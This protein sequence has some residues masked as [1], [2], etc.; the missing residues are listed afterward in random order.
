MTPAALII[1]A[2]N[3]SKINGSANPPL[4]ASYNGFVNGDNAGVL[5][6]APVLNVNA[7]T[8]SPVAGNP[9]AITVG[10]AAA[11]N[12]SISYVNGTLT[13]L[14]ADL[15]VSADNQSRVYGATNPV[16][17][18]SYSG[19]VNGESSGVLSGSAA[20]STPAD[21]NSPVG[22]YAIEV[23]QGTLSNAN[24]AGCLRGF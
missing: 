20:V 17:T 12:Y 19:W 2:V 3:Q 14:P 1:S 18:V 15:L 11:A 5:S 21:T 9:Y 7:D 23:S 24:S 8:N 16:L 4:T 22:S 13:V 6:T 10:G